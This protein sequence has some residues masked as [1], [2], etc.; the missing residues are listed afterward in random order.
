MPLCYFKKKK[1]K[2]GRTMKEAHQFFFLSNR[3]FHRGSTLCDS[4]EIMLTINLLT[5]PT[6]P[7][8]SGTRYSMI[9]LVLVH[10]RFASYVLVLSPMK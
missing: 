2:K 8:S 5:L 3:W 1:K 4:E 6:V 7:D 10:P 9:H